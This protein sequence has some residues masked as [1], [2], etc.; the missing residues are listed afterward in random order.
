MGPIFPRNYEM[1]FRPQESEISEVNNSCEN[2]EQKRSIPL[3]AYA[4]KLEQKVTKRYIE[5]ISATGIDPV[6]IEGCKNFEPDCLPPVE[7]TDR[8]FYLV[9][10]TSY[11]F[12]QVYF[13][14]SCQQIRG[15]TNQP[16]ILFT[17][18]I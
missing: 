3:S 6:L 4:N 9:S 5:K 15:C 13:T 11:Y 17:H 12:R 8:L 10:E 7:S 2:I 16:F 1:A 18:H 14:K